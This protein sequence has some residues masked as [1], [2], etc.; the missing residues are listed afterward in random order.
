LGARRG[1]F[2]Q[3]F[4]PLFAAKVAEAAHAA[5]GAK[6]DKKEEGKKED[7]EVRRR[8]TTRSPNSRAGRAPR[9][10]VGPPRR[11]RRDRPP[12]TT[13]ALTHARIITMKGDEVIEDGDVLVEGARICKI[14]PAGTCLS[15][16]AP[17]SS[18]LEGRTIMPGIVDVH[19]HMHY[20][21]LDIEHDTA[22]GVPRQPRLRRDHVA[23][24]VRVDRARLRAVGA[25]EERRHGRTRIFSTAT[26]SMAPRTPTRPRSNRSKRRRTT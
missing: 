8:R 16:R 3:K 24:S 22:L 10:P 7:D 2:Q 17:P 25:R 12:R 21:A 15:R 9:L 23:R 19:S 11:D 13:L 26:S 18:N 20:N 6:E 1:A 5:E 4:A 14:G